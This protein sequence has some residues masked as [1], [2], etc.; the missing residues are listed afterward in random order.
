MRKG[1]PMNSFKATVLAIFCG[2][3]S[4]TA[5]HAQTA[6]AVSQAPR[7]TFPERPAPSVP[8][9]FQGLRVPPG[10]SLRFLASE[11]GRS[12]LLATGHPI[13]PY[14]I[15]LFGEPSE[16]AV[17]PVS[18]YRDFESAQH[19]QAQTEEALGT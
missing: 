13:A 19:S 3:L 4:F 1:F 12:F 2:L 11:E 18:W 16:K 5:L 10:G 9:A 15:Q 6:I 17:V 7:A 14:A 8:A